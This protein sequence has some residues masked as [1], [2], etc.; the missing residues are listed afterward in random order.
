MHRF[1]RRHIEVISKVVHIVIVKAGKFR[2]IIAEVF[3]IVVPGQ[4]GC[5]IGKSMKPQSFSASLG[6]SLVRLT[7]PIAFEDAKTVGTCEGV[8]FEHGHGW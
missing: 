4:V 8:P 2:W 6:L 3:I 5:H 7:I 1:P